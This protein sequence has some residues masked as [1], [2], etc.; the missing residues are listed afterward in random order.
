M[1]VALGGVAAA[2]LLLPGCDVTGSPDH[3]DYVPYVPPAA[4]VTDGDRYEFADAG[5]E[6]RMTPIASLATLPEPSESLAPLIEFYD[7][8]G[9]LVGSYT[10]VEFR[11]FI[12][13]LVLYNDTSAIELDVP[14]S[15][16]SF[17]DTTQHYADFVNEIAIAPE[18]EIAQDDYTGLFFFF[19]SSPGVMGVGGTMEEPDGYVRQ[20]SRIVV[21]I[22]DYGGVWSDEFDENPRSDTPLPVR[23]N[24]ADDFIMFSPGALQPRYYAERLGLESFGE[25]AQFAYRVN[26][27]YRAILPG[28]DGHPDIWS[29][30]EP[31]T[32]GLPNHGSTGNASAIVMPFDGISV[33]SETDDVVITIG[34]DLDGIIEV[35]DNG[36]PNYQQDDV[37]VLARDFWRRFEISVSIE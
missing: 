7:S 30:D 32:L 15:E 12:Q 11:L 33:P 5:T 26:D 6:S 20:E 22:P 3:P 25:I 13:E 2:L 24:Y 23:T 4:S 19:F 18:V 35:Y 34:W 37:A 36:T 17:T 8:I 27:E 29:T 28:A 14:L 9:S 31:E 1:R 21:R 10:P 16:I